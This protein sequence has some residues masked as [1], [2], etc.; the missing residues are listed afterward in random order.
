MQLWSKVLWFSQSGNWM[1]QNIRRVSSFKLISLIEKKIEGKID[2]MRKKY[3]FGINKHLIEYDRYFL[4]TYYILGVVLG[5]RGL[6]KMDKIWTLLSRNSQSIIQCAK[7]I[8]WSHKVREVLCLE[9]SKPRT[10]PQS[11]ASIQITLIL[12]T[13]S[14]LSELGCK[15]QV[16]KF[17]SECWLN[18][19]RS[20]W[21][22][23]NRVDGNA[24]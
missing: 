17:A 18:E 11:R 16:E 4:S 15:G 5:V 21:W 6:K 3:E 2:F 7:I 8:S 9:I 24:I 20:V 1:M 19:D 14:W 23:L 12:K 13:C 22:L 10:R